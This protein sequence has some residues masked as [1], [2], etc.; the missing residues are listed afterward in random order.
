MFF[1]NVEQNQHVPLK[2]QYKLWHRWAEA[3]SDARSLFKGSH[4]QLPITHKIMAVFN[5]QSH[6]DRH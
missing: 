6:I 1:K 3:A 4:E 5:M 2:T